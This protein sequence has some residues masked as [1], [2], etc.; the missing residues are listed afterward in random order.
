MEIL[1]TYVKN[2]L[3]TV[4]IVKEPTFFNAKLA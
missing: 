3:I 1:E 2:A 4:P